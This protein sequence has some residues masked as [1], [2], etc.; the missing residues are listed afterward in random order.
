[1]KSR[2]FTLIELMI[3][4]AVLGVLAAIAY[5]S[6]IAQVQKAR[7]ADAKSALLAAAVQMQRYFTERS[8]YA[9]ATLGASGVYP[10]ASESGHYALSLT[11]TATT[12]TVS[13]APVGPQ[14]SDPCATFTYTDQ[15]VKGV[16][17]TAM[18]AAE[19]WR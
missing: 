4:V 3:V 17:G 12:F 7:R 18:T 8:T 13:A 6:Y 10:A 16:A 2:G 11:K 15:G 9:T 14:A 5:P 1:M 19:C